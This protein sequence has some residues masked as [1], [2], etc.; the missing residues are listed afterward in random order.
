ELPEEKAG[1]FTVSGITPLFDMKKQRISQ[2]ADVF[3]KYGIFNSHV[4]SMYA[5]SKLM[6]DIYT[7][8]ND[9]G[10]NF[11][12]N[13]A[14]LPWGGLFFTQSARH[15]AGH[16]NGINID[17]R[18][19]NPQNKQDSY[20]QS[21]AALRILDLNEYLKLSHW[22]STV[23]AA[24]TGDLYDK[25]ELIF[26]KCKN[27]GSPLYPCTIA[28][29][30]GDITNDKILKL[31]Q[32]HKNEFESTCASGASNYAEAILRYSTWVEYNLRDLRVIKKKLSKL[33]MSDGSLFPISMNSVISE[34]KKDWQRQAI[35]RGLWPDGT[36]IYKMNGN[37]ISTYRIDSCHSDLAGCALSEN[38]K[39][40][41]VHINH[42]HMEY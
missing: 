37:T 6:N 5:A 41:D 38:F 12:C 8:A 40:D 2:D 21:Y 23:A 9:M 28:T 3:C 4:V 32:W 30:I 18:Y 34:L 25:K 35:E 11:R 42:I 13:D 31:C 26:N 29:L 15:T 14:S 1:A 16:R 20:D 7:F 27:N 10:I 19:F 17:V 36:P 22:A 33:R 24:S 39:Y